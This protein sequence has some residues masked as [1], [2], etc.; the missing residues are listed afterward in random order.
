M[1]Y[2]VDLTFESVDEIVRLL[3]NLIPRAFPAHPSTKGK[4]LETK[5][6][7]KLLPKQYFAFMLLFFLDILQNVIFLFFKLR[8]T[9]IWAL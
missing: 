4:A 3:S 6:Q 5:A 8:L 2:K 7:L 9:F 1:L